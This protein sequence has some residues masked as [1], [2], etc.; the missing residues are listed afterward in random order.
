MVNLPNLVAIQQT[1]ENG[2]SCK[3]FGFGAVL[4]LSI[5]GMGCDKPLF[6]LQMQ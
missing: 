4:T 6:I 3:A 1:A 5:V 2:K